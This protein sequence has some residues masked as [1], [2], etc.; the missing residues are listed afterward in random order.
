MNQYLNSHFVSCNNS[1]AEVINNAYNCPSKF[2]TKNT[3]E[4][5]AMGSEN[6][7]KQTPIYKIT[8]SYADSKNL[9]SS[10]SCGHNCWNRKF[11]QKQQ[12]PQRK[13][14]RGSL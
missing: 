13:N 1:Y 8:G 12:Q 2:T 6:Y 9:Y 5:F 4:V 14:N 11:W 10:D 7:R 3:E